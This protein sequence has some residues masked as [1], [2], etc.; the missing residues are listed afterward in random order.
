MSA[1]LLEIYESVGG[2][3]KAG[4]E[5]AAA[6]TARIAEVVRDGGLLLAE[7]VVYHLNHSTQALGAAVKSRTP[8]ELAA[9]QRAWLEGAINR[10][11]DD[12]KA[13]LDLT[14]R[15]LTETAPAAVTPVAVAPAPVAVEAVAPAVAVEAA[16]APVVEEA[17][18]VEA[19]PVAEAAPAVEEVPAAEEA[20]IVAETTPV[21]EEIAAESAVSPT[22]TA[23]EASAEPVA[24]AS[25]ASKARGPRRG[26]A[27]KAEGAVVAAE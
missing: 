10:A 1:N 6:A 16:P 20:P 18:V 9:A 11:A 23:T 3:A 14:G 7:G 22:E 2:Y 19:A 4:A 5:Q 12:F 24:E 13:G 8:E 17:P 26:R 27:A 15:L 21:T 25:A